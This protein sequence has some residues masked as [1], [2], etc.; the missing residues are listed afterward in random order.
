[1][2]PERE[3]GRVS[4]LGRGKILGF[5]IIVTDQKLL[6]IDTRRYSI[7]LWLSMMLGLALGMI[8]VVSL[9]FS[10]LEPFLFQI[11][12]LLSFVTMLALVF[13][14]PIGMIVLVPRLLRRRLSQTSYS[15][16]SA[17]RKDIISIEAQRPGR[18]TQKGY[19]TIRLMNGKSFTFWTIG[20]DMF[21][22]VNS[23]LTSSYPGQMGP[24]T[25]EFAELEIDKPNN[26]LIAIIISAL[27]L[28]ILISAAFQSS[29]IP[30]DL[31]IKL[32]IGILVTHSIG[33]IGWLA[34]RRAWRWRRRR[35]GPTRSALS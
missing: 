28:T 17:P 30:S 21:D 33:A 20:Q 23:L 8:L 14:L 32:A 18:T 34:L 7:R 6:G 27:L 1:M 29:Y 5:T 10:G 24:R 19:F 2:E 35:N 12:P 4:G 26:R 16:L 25:R 9:I 22:H 13:S 11:S 31:F 3:L 15:T